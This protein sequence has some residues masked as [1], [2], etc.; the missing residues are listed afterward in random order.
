MN[1]H[2]MMGKIERLVDDAKV[3]V[4]ATVDSDGRPHV[5]WMTP[6][7]IPGRPGAVFAVTAPDFAKVHQLE[8]NPNVEWLFQ[9]RA[10]DEVV[11][12]RGRINVVDNP[13]LRSEVLEAV[14]HRLAIFWRACQGEDCVVLET[15][16]EEAVYQ[17]TAMHVREV[18]AFQLAGG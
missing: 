18:V 10:L 16:A 7:V 1:Q 4:L 15:V 9:S 13:S 17:R 14:G 2:E 8:A 5:R 6:A 11:N 12:L 3:A